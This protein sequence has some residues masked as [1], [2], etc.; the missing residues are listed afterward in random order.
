MKKLWINDNKKYV[1]DLD[2]VEFISSCV[3]IADGASPTEVW[4]VVNFP[5]GKSLTFEGKDAVSFY[6][7]YSNCGKEMIWD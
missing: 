4:T 6:N 7:S 5:S 3:P 1:I 2:K